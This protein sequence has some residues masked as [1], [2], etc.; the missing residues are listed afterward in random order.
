MN[1]MSPHMA[2][3]D[4]HFLPG[5]GGG[6]SDV[7]QLQEFKHGHPGSILCASNE[8]VKGPSYFLAEQP[9]PFIKY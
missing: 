9:L 1:F 8:G 5:R 2:G 7:V 4:S 6:L 3:Q